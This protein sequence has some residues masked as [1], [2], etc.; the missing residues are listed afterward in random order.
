MEWAALVFCMLA[1]LVHIASAAMSVWRIR[2]GRASASSASSRPA[3]PPVTVIRPV[4]GLDPFDELTLRSTFALAHPEVELIFC[5]ARERDTAVPLVRQLIA[6]HPDVDAKLLVGDDKSTPNPKLNNII[7]GWAVARHPWIVIA[8]SNVLMPR[9]Y[10]G[11][12]FAAMRE[13]TG[14]VCSPPVGSRPD[15][16]WGEVECAFLNT[17]QARWQLAA[18]TIGFGFAQGKSMLWRRDLL[19]A[20]GGIQALGIEVAEDAAATK[21]VRAQGL[22][23]R[24]V[25][26][27]F[28]QPL[29]PRTRQQIL[30]RQVR[31]ARLRRATF[32]LCYAP[33]LLTGSLAPMGAAMVAAPLAGLDSVAAAGLVVLVW[34]GTEAVLAKSAGW[35][36]SPVSPFAWLVRDLVLPLVWLKGW[37]GDAFT[38]RG[39]DMTVAEADVPPR[40]QQARPEAALH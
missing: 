37:I 1:A 21:V 18:D 28:E 19:D 17:Y 31:W 33:E 40:P 3:L 32:P 23:V 11:Q 7:K 16:F 13:D 39:N 10:I 25:D 9:D 26:A 12:L 38:W 2:R 36:V 5:S 6:E 22:R 20:A 34:F 29:G 24:L 14:L 8:D 4:C 27:P 15:G 35:H 30:D